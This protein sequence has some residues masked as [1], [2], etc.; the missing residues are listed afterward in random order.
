MNGLPL[1]IPQGEVRAW[2]DLRGIEGAERRREFAELVDALD[3]T[4]L[5]VWPT[6]QSG[7]SL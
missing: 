1:G 5:R 3:A 2:L 4:F 6:V 7:R